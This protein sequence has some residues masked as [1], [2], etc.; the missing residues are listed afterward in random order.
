MFLYVLVVSSFQLLLN[1]GGIYFIG[2]TIGVTL[3]AYSLFLYRK[4]KPLAAGQVMAIGAML[5]INIDNIGR[6]LF[7]SESGMQYRIYI[8]ML[9]LAGV[10]FLLILFFR[11]RKTIYTYSAFFE[12][13]ILVH[14]IIIHFQLSGSADM[15]R[16]LW[17]HFMMVTGDIFVI[18]IISTFML[19]YI[20]TLLAENAEHAQQIAL[21]N[22]MLEQ[23]VEERTHELK[24]SNRH[25]K[26][27]A[28]I[29]SHDLK[30]PLRTISGFVTLIKRDLKKMGMTTQEIEDYIGY[31]SKGTTQMENLISDILAYS[32]LN[33]VEKNFSEVDMPRILGDVK[34]SLARALDE[35]KAE[36]HYG[37]FIN[38]NG[39]RL[40]LT[41][42]FQNLI[43]NAIKYR[44][45]ARQLQIT[46][47][48]KADGDDVKYFVQDNG[49]GISEQYYETIFQAFKRLH[50]KAKYEGTGVGLA[51][52][53]KIVDIHGGEIWVESKEGEGSTFWF[54]LPKVQTEIAAMYPVV[55]AA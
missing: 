48:C 13:I 11:D 47:G 9:G 27:F 5:L 44:S 43:S 4:A 17:Q 40:L 53:K 55:H 35:S 14:T 16:E 41:Q 24:K 18:A 26:E 32:K 45:S 12:L 54:T 52:C 25:L 50:S 33:V 42:L 23:A 22:E 10:D 38:V 19:R 21:Q 6:D 7:V 49:I 15:Q 20:E 46:I 28:Y 31:V 1:F 39:E 34:Q 30:E 3:A 51:I 36:L 37:K 8:T 29:V 2:D